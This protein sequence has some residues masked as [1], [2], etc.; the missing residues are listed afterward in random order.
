MIRPLFENMADLED[1]DSLDGNDDPNGESVE[2]DALS[3][4]SSKL[5]STAEG[6]PT[7]NAAEVILV[8]ALIARA[9]L[10]PTDEFSPERAATLAALRANYERLSRVSNGVTWASAERSLKANPAKLDKLKR[11]LEERPGSDLTVVGRKDGEIKF[12][13]VAALCPGVLN[14]AYDKAG[15]IQAE[16]RYILTI[17]FGSPGQT[18]F[19][20]SPKTCNGNAVEVAASFGAKPASHDLYETLR[21]KEIPGL[22]ESTFSWL[23]TDPATRE[24]GLALYGDY[25]KVRKCPVRPHRTNSGVRCEIGVEEV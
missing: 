17:V 1:P 15:Q 23:L 7:L 16:T 9:R 3:R 5:D 13:E 24:S 10:K 8:K 11:L 14:L 12:M 6:Q 2:E 25:G 20:V 18:T 21:R 22:D 4:L 19:Q